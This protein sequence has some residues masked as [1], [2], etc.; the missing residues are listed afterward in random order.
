MKFTELFKVLFAQGNTGFIIIALIALA[1]IAIVI[2]AIEI[3]KGSHY[4]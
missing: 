2:G 4:L 1:I 3:Y